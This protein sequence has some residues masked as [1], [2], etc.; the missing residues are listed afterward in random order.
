MTINYDDS[1]NITVQQGPLIFAL[2][3]DK[4]A[5]VV[6]SNHEQVY[7]T[8]LTI[9]RSFN[10]NEQEYIVTSIK[11]NSFRRIHDISSIQFPSD[12]EVRIIESGAFYDCS[13]EEIF[14][15]PSIRYLVDGWLPGSSEIRNVRMISDNQYYKNYNDNFIIGKSDPN[16]EEYDV[17]VFASRDI[18]EFTIPSFITQI[19]PYCFSFTEI[20][21]M[22]IPPQIVRIGFG[23]FSNCDFIEKVEFHPDSQLEKIEYDLFSYSSI[24][25]VTFPSK[26]K[27]IEEHAFCNC[28]VLVSVEFTNDSQLELIEKNAFWNSPIRRIVIPSNTRLSEGWCSLTSNLDEVKLI[29][30]KDPILMLTDDNLIIGKSDTKSDIFDVLLFCPRVNKT[31]T[32]PPSVC[33]IESYSFDCSSIVNLVIPPNVT[34]IGTHAFAQTKFLNSIEFSVDSKLE[35]IDEL[36]FYESN[37]MKISIPSCVSK[38]GDGWI[39]QTNRLR[40][41]NVIQNEKQNILFYQNNFIVGKSDIKSDIYDDLIYV[42][43]KLRI[44]KV[45]PFI[46]RIR[47]YAFCK[48]HAV[49]VEIPDEVETIEKDA[50]HNSYLHQIEFSPNTKIKEIKDQTFF[51]S[52]I[53]HIC[54]P[55]Q[56]TSIGDNAFTFCKIFRHLTIPVNSELKKIGKY[57]ISETNVKSLWIPSC[58]TFIDKAAFIS[59]KLLIIQFEENSELQTIKASDICNN[60]VIIMMPMKLKDQ[61]I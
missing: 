8:N 14:L 47:E 58:V 24:K 52:S 4:T 5:S 57:V 17:L 55:S 45:P 40:E 43:S 36:A 38:L 34:H 15:P 9:P 51:R 12:S 61:I 44:A 46:K 1:N 60:Q 19:A 33:R 23:S 26:V 6:G 30:R 22:F 25:S 35:V 32:I 56:V 2:N 41:I 54:L 18:V 29:P 10:Y 7:D 48:S 16:N 27:Q 59:N 39:A 49:I 31:A 21:Y 28:F 3:E 42:S 50:F 37:V 53:D 20:T 11:K 13:P